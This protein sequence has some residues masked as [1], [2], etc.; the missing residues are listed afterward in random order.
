MYVCMWCVGVCLC[1]Y[2]YA[3]RSV[4]D[5]GCVCFRVC[6]CVLRHTAGLDPVNGFDFMGL[7]CLAHS[8]ASRLANISFL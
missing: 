5:C 2:M 8:A 4:I 6:E 7:P 1:M 3:C